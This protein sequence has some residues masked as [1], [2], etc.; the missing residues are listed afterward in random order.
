MKSSEDKKWWACI[1]SG[2]IKIGDEQYW[3][4]RIIKRENVK[5]KVNGV[6][7]GEDR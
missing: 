3:R 2:R 7:D 5:E 4:G 6:G 1:L